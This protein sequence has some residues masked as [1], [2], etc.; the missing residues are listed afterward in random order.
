VAER[1]GVGDSLRT[2]AFQPQFNYTTEIVFKLVCQGEEGAVEN[3]LAVAVTDALVER[4]CPDPGRRQAG[5]GF[6]F[7][8]EEIRD[9]IDPSQPGSHPTRDLRLV[10]LRQIKAANHGGLAAALERAGSPCIGW[11]SRSN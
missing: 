2:P 6:G 8:I 11:A 1:L 7:R 3:C 5:V 10:A 4:F 9:L